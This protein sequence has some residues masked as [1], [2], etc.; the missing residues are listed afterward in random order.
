M[1]YEIRRQGVSGL[2]AGA[3]L[4]LGATVAPADDAPGAAWGLVRGGGGL[5]SPQEQPVWTCRVSLRTAIS[6]SW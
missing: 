5:T 3:L 2:L 4:L 1:I 6:T